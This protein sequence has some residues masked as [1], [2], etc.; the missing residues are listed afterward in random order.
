MIKDEAW[1]VESY[2]DNY[3]DCGEEV[4]YLINVVLKEDNMFG[5]PPTPKDLPYYSQVL[6]L[7]DSFIIKET[8]SSKEIWFNIK[9]FELERD[10]CCI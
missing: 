4:E 9:K 5:L 2:E 6:Y 8:C 1:D 7:G 10:M 3:F